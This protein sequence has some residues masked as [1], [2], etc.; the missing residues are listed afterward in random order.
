MVFSFQA[1]KKDRTVVYIT[2]SNNTPNTPVVNFTVSI[3]SNF[4]KSAPV[5]QRFT[6]NAATGQWVIGAKGC[7]FYFPANSLLNMGNIAVT[8]TADIELIEYMN[9]ADMLFSGVTVGS[10]NQLLESGGMFYL[11]AKQ[12]GVE[13][14]LKD[15]CGFQIK[16]PQTNNTPDPMDF[17][18]GENN[19]DD[20]LNKVDWVKKDT[21]QIVPKQDTAH[22]SSYNIQ[23]NYFKF[24]YCNIDREWSKF[25]TLISKFRIKMPANCN[26]TNSTAL[27]LFKNYNCCAW[28]SWLTAEKAI[29]THY[30]LPLG[31]T[32]K[33][34]VYKKT[35]PKEDDLEYAIKEI[36]LTDDTQV[37]FTSLVK[38]T[39]L[40]LEGFIKAL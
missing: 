25:K 37:D 7:R 8:G 38:C 22:F 5:L 26:D 36:V 12:N 23:F 39:N 21:V 27:L 18:I 33:V 15:N 20:S 30:Q 24:G 32:M 40:E 11:I 29:A 14:K 1:C 6:I 13:L 2:P 10:G 4:K 31:E 35:G 16:I 9:K 3:L 19:V 17:W 34:L 28:C